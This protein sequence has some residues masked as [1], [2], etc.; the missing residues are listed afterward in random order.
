V[1]GEFG[2]SAVP[3]FIFFRVRTRLVVLK[4]YSN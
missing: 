3:T 2:I 4:D 1:S